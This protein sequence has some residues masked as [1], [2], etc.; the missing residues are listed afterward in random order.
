MLSFNQL[1]T[2]I[3]AALLLGATII[4]GL[5]AV[6]NGVISMKNSRKTTATQYCYAKVE[7]QKPANIDERNDLQSLCQSEENLKID[8]NFAQTLNYISCFKL[9]VPT[10]SGSTSTSEEILSAAGATCNL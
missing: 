7:S 9:I 6:E 4:H 10:A 3:I 1:V 2:A 5:T 8:A